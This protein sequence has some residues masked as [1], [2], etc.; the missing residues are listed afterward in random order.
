MKRTREGLALQGSLWRPSAA[1]LRD[2]DSFRTAFAAALAPALRADVEETSWPDLS[3][4]EL[5]ALTEQYAADE[6]QA[7]R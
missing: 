7:L 5:G 1:G 4:E 3:D 6:W 2:W